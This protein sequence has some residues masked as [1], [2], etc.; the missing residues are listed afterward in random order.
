MSER[1]RVRM[2]HHERRAAIL[3]SALQLFAE[4]GFR[5]TT[6]RELANA[7]GVTEPVLYQHFANKNELYLAIVEAKVAEGRE[8]YAV[9][10]KHLEGDRDRE[11]F[12][13]LASLI[14]SRYEQDPEFIRLLLFSA[15]ERHELARQFF[16]TQVARFNDVVAGYIRRRM[17]E[18]AFRNVSPQAAARSFIG[19]VQEHGFVGALFGA[20][21]PRTG[22][23]KLIDE[24]VSIFLDGICVRAAVPRSKYADARRRLALRILRPGSRRRSLRSKV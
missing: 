15:L 4:K 9:L 14:L 7:L 16:D 17:R 13:H 12:T 23:K 2:K 1:N 22:R 5:G 24:I 19:M 3:A 10:L 8:D 11:V 20:D 21:R 6:T 18:G